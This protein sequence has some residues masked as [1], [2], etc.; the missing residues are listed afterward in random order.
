M[1]DGFPLLLYIYN[2]QGKYDTPLDIP[3]RLGLE[4]L[5]ET[6]IKPAIEAGRKVII[7]DCGDDCVLHAEGGKVLFPRPD[8]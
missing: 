1:E 7:T 6:T 4:I 5:M 8:S 2:E 3:T